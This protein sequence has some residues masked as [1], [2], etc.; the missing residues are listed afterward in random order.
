M[1]V[2]IEQLDKQGY[3]KFGIVT[4]LI[5]LGLFGLAIPYLFSLTYPKWPW[6]IASVLIVLALL[7]P[8]ALTYP[9]QIWMKFGQVMNWINTRIILGI[10]F[11][12]IFF[13]VGLL[14]KLFGKDPMHRKLDKKSSSY[15]EL[16]EHDSKTNLER[17]Y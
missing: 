9:Y 14:L 6:Y 15:R 12:V 5:L 16:N 2:E 10:L 7:V 1:S 11:Y 13:P 4:G 8:M 3:R 17:P